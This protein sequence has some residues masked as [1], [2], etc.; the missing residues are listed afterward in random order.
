MS[1]SYSVVAVLRVAGLI[2]EQPAKN[3]SNHKSI[4]CTDNGIRGR[5]FSYSSAAGAMTIRAKVARSLAEL[6]S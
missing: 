3:A 4:F 5:K 1:V 2:V 6:D